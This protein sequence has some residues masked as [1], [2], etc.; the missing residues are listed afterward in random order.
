MDESRAVGEL[1]KGK[2]TTLREKHSGEGIFFTSKA[3]DILG[4]RSHKINLIFDNKK[5]DIFLEEKRLISG[6][7]VKFSIKKITRKNLADIFAAYS[8]E[9]LEY[10]FEK[11]KV[12]VKLF[13]NTYVSRSEAKRL[14]F[15]LDKF[16]EIILDFKGVK[17]IGQ[18]F[19]DE[20]FRVFQNSHQEILIK[21]ENASE[22]LNSMLQRYKNIGSTES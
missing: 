5:N 8:P 11:T 17:S 2:T 1:I 13:Q 6:T 3:A 14:L 10:R 19:A 18:G 22:I 21:T 20:I 16:K 7:E 15:G 12:A 9:E 4:I